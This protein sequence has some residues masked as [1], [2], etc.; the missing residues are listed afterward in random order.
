HVFFQVRGLALLLAQQNL[1]IQQ[2]Q[3]DPG[4]SAECRLVAQILFDQSPLALLPALPLICQQRRGG[5]QSRADYRGLAHGFSSSS[6]SCCAT[7]STARDKRLRSASG[8]PPT[9]AAIA[10]HSSPSWR[11]SSKRRSSGDRRRRASPTSSRKATCWLG[12]ASAEAR[13]TSGS[14]ETGTRRSWSPSSSRRRALSITLFRA[15]VAS[16][17]S[18]SSGLLSSY[19]PRDTRTKKLA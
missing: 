19:W 11:S 17:L 14:S 7:R 6:P 10:G 1:V 12:V 3:D 2:I 5:R 16:S 4:L 18:R 8:L 9:R 13:A 15:M